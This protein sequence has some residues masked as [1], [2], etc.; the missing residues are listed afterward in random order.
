MTEASIF[1]PQR[2]F[3]DRLWFEIKLTSCAVISCQERL[4]C[5]LSPLIHLYKLYENKLLIHDNVTPTFNPI[6]LYASCPLM[7]MC[8]YVYSSSLL[9][10][11][12]EWK[13]TGT[14]V[15]LTLY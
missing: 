8:L 12:Q 9:V 1:S 3:D 10:L 2:V 11:V 14:E 7:L 15:C 5:S 13:C 4:K 6:H